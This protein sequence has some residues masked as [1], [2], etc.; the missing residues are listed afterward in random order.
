MGH[1]S[2]SRSFFFFQGN[3]QWDVEVRH[4]PIWC[5]IQGGN[6]GINVFASMVEL[7]N[8]FSSID[9]LTYQEISFSKRE[10]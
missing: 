2:H 8:C 7:A 1:P 3:V 5:A 6:R 10:S 4:G 9:T